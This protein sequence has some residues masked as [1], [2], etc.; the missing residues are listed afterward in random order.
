MKKNILFDELVGELVEK[1]KSYVIFKPTTKKEL[2][3]A[4]MDWVN[5]SEESENKYG[6]INAWDIS[7]LDDLS[8]LFGDSDCDTYHRYIGEKYIDTSFNENI[9]NWNTSN[10]KNMEGLF[11]NLRYFNQPLNNWDVSNVENMS[12]MFAGSMFFDQSLD[13]WNT[14]K[15]TNMSRMFGATYAFYGLHVCGFNH[16]INNWDVSNVNDMSYMFC[17]CLDYDKPLD[18]WNLSNVKSN[19]AMLFHT[20]FDESRTGLKKKDVKFHKINEEKYPL[21]NKENLFSFGNSESDYDEDGNPS[22]Y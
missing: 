3:N 17:D 21:F 5:D 10:V 12:N 2:Q 18:N 8:Y 19:T 22:Y 4:L 11:M 14:S 1:I 13:K 7:L 20:K 15:V 16:N 6:Q 9:S